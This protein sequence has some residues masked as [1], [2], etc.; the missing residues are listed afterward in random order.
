MDIIVSMQTN[1]DKYFY[2][3]D[4]I[5]PVGIVV[6]STGANNPNAKRYVNAPDLLGVNQY[7]NW[8]GGKNSNDVLPHGV[9]GLDKNGEVVAC[10][11][12]P[13][14]AHCQGCGTG[15]KGS[16]NKLPDGN[17]YIQFEICEDALNNEEYFNKAFD[18]AAE[19]CAYLMRLY[20]DI[21]LENV[22]SHKEANA[23]GY[24]SGH[25]DPENWLTP[26]KKNMDWFRLLVSDHL[27]NDDNPPKV[28]L[29]R[30]QVG[31]FKD[32]KNAENLLADLK[33]K[34]YE[35]FIVESEVDHV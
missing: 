5:K 17:G 25:G 20:P 1:S 3:G 30:V 35:G 34:G 16:Y 12:L 32:R 4:V 15:S 22:V 2:K 18:K 27:E 24:A 31:A 19:L 9:I 26:F 13:W 14:N 8:F 6:H 11:I 21:R 29:Y 10:Q 23:R 28:K 7:E 33:N